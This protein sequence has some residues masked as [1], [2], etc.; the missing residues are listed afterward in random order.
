MEKLVVIELGASEITFS[1]LN[2]TPNGYF[3][4]EQQIKE[5]VRLT[6]DL[7]R[8]GYIKSARIEET[9]SILKIFRKIMDSEQITNYLCYADPVLA[10]AR[11]QI[12]FLDEIYKTISLHFRVLTEEEQ[13]DAL[14]LASLHSLPIARGLV[15]QIGDDSVQLINYNRR[16]IV[17]QCTLPFGAL[18]LAEK[19]SD[20]T[21]ISDKMDKMV[22][23]V[24]AHIR[25]EKWLFDLD[26]ET[27]YI[28]L[29]KIFPFWKN[30]IQP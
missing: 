16:T 17:N 2:F 29:G 18:S 11:N 13:V 19:F 7:E 30:M 5:P 20:I 23:L 25:K 9:I 8:D 4:L 27:E 24:T 15:C 6:Q 26:E 1:K 10:T 21:N 12:A 14:H 22:D 28:G 3:S